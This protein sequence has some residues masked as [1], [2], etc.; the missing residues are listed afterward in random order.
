MFRPS[1]AFMKVLKTSNEISVNPT[2]PY[3]RTSLHGLD[4]SDFLDPLNY[5]DTDLKKDLRNIGRFLELF[6]DY[7]PTVPLTSPCR[8]SIIIPILEKH[9]YEFHHA[10]KYI[11]AADSKRPETVEAVWEFMKKV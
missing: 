7:I 9:G 6:G 11:L 8:A 4:E 5:D 2:S 3:Y 1:L 10:S